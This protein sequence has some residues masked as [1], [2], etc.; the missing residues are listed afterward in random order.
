M[1]AVTLQSVVLA[2]GGLLS[3]GSITI[4]ILLL[5]STRGGSKGLAYV[6]GYLGAYALIG[7]GAVAAGHE[8]AA[9]PSGG[10]AVASS[11]VF[12]VL[13]TLLLW[14]AVR[15]WRRRAVAADGLPRF[16]AFV[17][18]VT[19][20]KALALGAAVTVLNVKNLAIYLSAVSVALV[21]DLPL[22]GKLV[23]AVLDALVFCAAVVAPLVIYAAAPTAARARLSRIQAALAK[24]GRA[25]RIW[26]PAIFGVLFLV[27][28]MRG[29]L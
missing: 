4:V 19:P 18:Q 14:I 12:A 16:L 23:I 6:L 7:L 26:V 5:M 21:S 13:G 24:H 10:L 25:I 1:L 2:A 20:V 15:S 9:D 22:S 8:A 27:Q 3:P 29:L 17:D 28:A 11:I